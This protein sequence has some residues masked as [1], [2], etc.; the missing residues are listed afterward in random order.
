MKEK[1]Y[2]FIRIQFNSKSESGKTNLWTVMSIQ[3]VYLGNIK[4]F[5]AWRCYGFYPIAGTVFEKQCLK[6]IANFCE[7]FADKD[8]I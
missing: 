2:K 8:L 5:G 4:W 7:E 1:V 6:D 3:G